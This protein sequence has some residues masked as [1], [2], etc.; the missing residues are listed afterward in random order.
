[1]VLKKIRYIIEW[2]DQYKQIRKFVSSHPRAQKLGKKTGILDRGGG[3]E[4]R[5][6]GQNIDGWFDMY[7]A[8]VPVATAISGREMSDAYV[9]QP[10][11]C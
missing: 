7:W 3:E 10:M 5:I 2:I 6:C 1:M 8:R 9:K 4:N 11:A